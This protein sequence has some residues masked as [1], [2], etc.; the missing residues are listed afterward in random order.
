MDVLFLIRGLHRV[1][2]KHDNLIRP[3]RKRMC[4]EGTLSGRESALRTLNPKQALLDPAPLM[5]ATR[6]MM[7]RQSRGGLQL[8]WHNTLFRA[9]GGEQ[10]CQI[11][12]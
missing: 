4:G 9:R 5:F 12:D 11:W 8:E 10:M 3:Y 2:A 7:L 6:S 1:C